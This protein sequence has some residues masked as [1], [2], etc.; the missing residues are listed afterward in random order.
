M[1]WRCHYDP[2]LHDADRGLARD[3]KPQI[4]Q[5]VANHKLI[6]AH[7]YVSLLNRSALVSKSNAVARAFAEIIDLYCVHG[8]DI[9][10]TRK[11]R[12]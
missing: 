2:S 11:E 10:S 12:V 5:T 3:L 4:K 7:P 1:N 6:T 9:R 8:Q